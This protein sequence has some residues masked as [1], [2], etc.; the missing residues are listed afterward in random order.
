MEGG[1]TKE[2]KATEEVQK[3]CDQVKSQAEEKA[4][5][6]FNQFQAISY[7]SQVVAGMNYIIKVDVGNTPYNYVHLYVYQSLA[8]DGSTLEVTTIKTGMKESAPLEPIK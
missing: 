5:T 1:F 3:I 8:S 2:M 7:R 6:T 4:G